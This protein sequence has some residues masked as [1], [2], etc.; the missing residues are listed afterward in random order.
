ML[1]SLANSLIAL[2]SWH[3]ITW[4]EGNMVR[5]AL[6]RYMDTMTVSSSQERGDQRSHGVNHNQPQIGQKWV[7]LDNNYS[8][9]N[10]YNVGYLPFVECPPWKNLVAKEAQILRTVETH[11][12]CLRPNQCPINKR[13]LPYM[14]TILSTSSLRNFDLSTSRMRWASNDPLVSTYA[15]VE[16][17]AMVI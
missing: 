11:E 10:T 1:C 2:T 12:S 7:I 14:I 17:V 3:M 13:S 4:P 15:T 16:P 8:M 6:S 9:G 5:H